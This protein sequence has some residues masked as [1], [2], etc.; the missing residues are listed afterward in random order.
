MTK[1]RSHELDLALS[2]SNSFDTND[3][4]HSLPG[5]A[6]HPPGVP[7][8]HERAIY[9]C[10][11][12][13]IVRSL[14]PT[15]HNAATTLFTAAETNARFQFIFD[16]LDHNVSESFQAVHHQACINQKLIL[17]LSIA[18][19]EQRQAEFITGV[20]LPEERYAVSNM[21]D[22]LLLKQCQPINQ[23]HFRENP[24]GVCTRNM[25]I[26]FV[27]NHLQKDGFLN[28]M[29]HQ[30]V[31]EVEKISGQETLLSFMQ[32]LHRPHSTM[33]LKPLKWDVA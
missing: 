7:V 5:D 13:D 25:P 11:E 22:V 31:D 2:H 33:S 14:L 27:Y 23:Y 6:H 28:E 29:S 19:A 16:L 18:M 8:T 21:G 9:S 15:T 4:S 20:L 10:S 3:Y 1:Y 30:I 32:Q 17:D 26:T 24:Q 12:T